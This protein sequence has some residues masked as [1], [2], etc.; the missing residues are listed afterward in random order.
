[1]RWR[2]T[3]AILLL[4]FL[5][6]GG[7]LMR[8]T[9][10]ARCDRIEAPLLSMLQAL[11]KGEAAKRSLL[12]EAIISWQASRLYFSTLTDHE[13]IDNV[14]QAFARIEAFLEKE[15]WAEAQAE[16]SSLLALLERLRDTDRLFL[17]NLL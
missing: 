9:T 13:R 14:N 16:L 4:V 15:E 3:V 17:R 5:P 6:L 2:I 12:D 8:R 10:Q 1:M 11:R 7:G